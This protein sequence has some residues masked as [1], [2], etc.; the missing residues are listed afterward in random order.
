MN[1][2]KWREKDIVLAKATIKKYN[3]KV[4][5]LNKK[6]QNVFAQP[7]EKINEKKFLNNVITDRKQFN[8]AIKSMERLTN[9]RNITTQKYL[10]REKTIMLAA[11]TRRETHA[12]KKV[13]LD[14]HDYVGGSEQESL[15]KDTITARNYI[16]DFFMSATTHYNSSWFVDRITQ[17]LTS[18]IDEL[19]SVVVAKAIYDAVESAGGTKDDQPFW[20]LIKTTEIYDSGQAIDEVATIIISKFPDFIKKE[21]GDKAEKEISVSTF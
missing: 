17:A 1:N 10:K 20:S 11:A 12:L 7:L 2:M 3:A 16:D 9:N 18:S 8:L 19:G 6:N 15:T 14:F 21:M 4:A 13:R 5:R